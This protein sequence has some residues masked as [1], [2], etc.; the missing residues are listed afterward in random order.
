M[1]WLGLT[2]ACGG[3]PEKPGT[4]LPRLTREQLMNPETCK[5]CH[6]RHYREWSSSMHAY[7]AQDPVFL[8][9]NQRGQ[10]ETDGEL[11]DFCVNCHAPMAVREGLTTD[12]LNL[13]DVPE[14][15]QGVTCYFCHNAVERRWRPQRDRSRWRTTDDA[16]RRCA[17]PSSRARTTWQ[18][19]SLHDR[20][21]LE[22]SALCG[23]C[24]DIVTPNGVHLERT[25]AEYKESIFGKHG[26]ASIDLRRLPHE[27][28]GSGAPVADAARERAAEPH[29]CTSTCGRAS[30][31]R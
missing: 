8:A 5:G 24:H 1:F 28:A 26:T 4:T 27:G 18:Y 17:I 23:G 20:N 11:G 9:M 12:G 31:W 14:Q 30:T 15:L 16:R 19:S 29:R 7:A 13:A 10:R 25:F 2:A 22:S 21:S 6:P 3:D